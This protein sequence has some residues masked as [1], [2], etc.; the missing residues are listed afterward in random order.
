MT[1]DV[2]IGDWMATATGGCV[3]PLDPRPEDVNIEDIAYSL[4]RQ[5]RFAG[6]MR[7]EVW[8]YSVAQHSVIVSH[9]CAPEHALIGL[10]HD[11]SEYVVQDIVRP[12]KHSLGREY[13]DAERAWLVAIGFRFGLGQQLLEMPDDVKLADKRALAA[14]RRDLVDHRDRPWAVKADPLPELVFPVDA[15][16]AFR[17]F[18][19]RFD[20]LTRKPIAG[21]ETSERP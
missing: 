15:H 4:A 1:P 11:A 5:C 19:N 9:A 21:S 8:H 14:E 7:P 10:L 20:A 6:H 13:H 12:F 17:L 18:M 2:R 16:T 3:W